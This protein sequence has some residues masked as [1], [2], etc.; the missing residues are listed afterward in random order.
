[1]AGKICGIKEPVV[2]GN[3]MMNPLNKDPSSFKEGSL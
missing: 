3:W 1:M 2:Q